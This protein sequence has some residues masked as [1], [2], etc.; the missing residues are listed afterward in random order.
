MGPKYISYKK[1]SRVFLKTLS[2]VREGPVDTYHDTETIFTLERGFSRIRDEFGTFWYQIRF[3]V[4]IHADG[5][6]QNNNVPV[7]S[8]LR[9]F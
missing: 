3:V 1:F 4:L 8:R 2:R 6:I 9:G 7:W 5:F